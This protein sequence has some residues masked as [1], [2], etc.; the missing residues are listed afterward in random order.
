MLKTCG[1]IVGNVTQMTL[2]VCGGVTHT[3]PSQFLENIWCAVK[4]WIA[5]MSM[6][7][8]AI[9][10]AGIALVLFVAA[11][12]R[13][14]SGARRKTPSEPKYIADKEEVSA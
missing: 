7:S 6:L 10:I 9:V 2:G 4:I 11:V 1:Q 3:G 5:D 14:S 13:T 12:V 8:T